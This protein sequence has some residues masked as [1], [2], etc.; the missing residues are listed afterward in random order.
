MNPY[1]MSPNDSYA[2]SAPAVLTAGDSR[3]SAPYSISRDY[4]RI[5][6]QDAEAE[7]NAWVA[8]VILV[9]VAMAVGGALI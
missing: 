1:L 9:F 7:I 5:E 4:R 3:R 6:T 2:D 8:I